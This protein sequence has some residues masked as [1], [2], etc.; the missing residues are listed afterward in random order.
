MIRIEA[1]SPVIQH[2]YCSREKR[3][4][5]RN[6]AVSVRTKIDGRQFKYGVPAIKKRSGLW[7]SIESLFRR[8]A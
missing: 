4:R 3:R 8:S 5:T 1:A 7:A 2:Y 6:V